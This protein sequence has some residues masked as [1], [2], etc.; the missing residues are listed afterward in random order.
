ATIRE[1]RHRNRV[2]VETKYDRGRSRSCEHLG[3]M[4]DVFPFCLNFPLTLSH[5]STLQGSGTFSRGTKALTGVKVSKPLHMDQG[6][7]AFIASACM[8]RAVMSKAKQYPAKKYCTSDPLGSS[9]VPPSA[10]Y[11]DVGLR[12]MIG[13]FGTG[14]T[15]VRGFLALFNTTYTAI[16]V[17][18]HCILRKPPPS[19]H[20]G[21]ANSREI[22][23]HRDYLPPDLGEIPH[24]GGGETVGGRC[25]GGV[26]ARGRL[27]LWR[28][29][30]RLRLWR[31]T[32]R[33]LGSTRGRALEQRLA[34]AGVSVRDGSVSVRGLRES[35]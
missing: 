20:D 18:E 9:T 35:V 3:Y 13:V 5:R 27:R 23:P 30:G 26:R 2:R 22:P 7:P 6:S 12:K 17:D 25:G 1:A 21:A 28:E 4:S 32:E 24:L 10:R 8:S 29:T 16:A 19:L 15:A 34:R 33:Q 14:H 31:E 11:D